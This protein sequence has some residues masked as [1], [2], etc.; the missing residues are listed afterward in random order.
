MILKEADDRA[1]DLG[2]LKRLRDTSPPSFRASI[3]KQI[4]NIH[5]GIA[6]ER[7]AAHFLKREFGH[8]KRVLILHD[9]RIGVDGDYARLTTSYSTALKR[10]LGF[11]KQRTT[12]DASIA[13]SMGIGPSGETGSRIPSHPRVIRRAVTPKLCAFGW[14]RMASR[15]SRGSTRSS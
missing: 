13:M 5:K 2:E 10:R 15:R 9:L 1:E 3:Q 7:E 11:L 8:S 12:P 6:G 14:K 4:D